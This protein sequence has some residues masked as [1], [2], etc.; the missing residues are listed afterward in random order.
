M[1][2]YPLLGKFVSASFR[3]L[4]PNVRYGLAASTTNALLVMMAKVGLPMPQ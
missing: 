3:E 2:H 1:Q 4:Q